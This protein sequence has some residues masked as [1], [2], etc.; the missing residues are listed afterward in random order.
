MNALFLAALVTGFVAGRPV[1]VVCAPI[2]GGHAGYY[3]VRRDVITLDPL[4][5]VKFSAPASSR[6]KAEGVYALVHEAEHARG[7]TDEHD[8][9]C[10][11]LRDFPAVVRRAGMTA[12]LISWAKRIHDALPVPYSGACA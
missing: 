3:D 8:A 10:A 7:I 1:P 12:K 2:Q 9:D 5:C 4:V 6:A 11:A